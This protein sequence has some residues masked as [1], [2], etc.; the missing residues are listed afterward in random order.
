MA[1]IVMVTPLLLPTGQL[2]IVGIN[3]WIVSCYYCFFAE[4]H[5]ARG[6][7]SGRKSLLS[8]FY[9]RARGSG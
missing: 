4:E 6:P 8:K 3:D 7:I 9:G 5:I 1:S 2:Q